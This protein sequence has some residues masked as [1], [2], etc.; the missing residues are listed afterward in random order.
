MAKD[1]YR[2]IV[3]L[4]LTFL[5]ARL[6][7]KTNKEPEEYLQPTTKDFPITEEYFNF[8]IGEIV[9]KGLIRG[10]NITKAW[11]GDIVGVSGIENCRITSDGIEYLSE[12]GSMRAALEQLRNA[13]TLLP[14]M[15][16]TIID[17]LSP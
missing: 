17:L 1:D 7:G 16:A 10:V 5:Y 14:G 12:N 9:D 2:R 4:M 15:V 13:A 8:V 11:G 3:C 6:K